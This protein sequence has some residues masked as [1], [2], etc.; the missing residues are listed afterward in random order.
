MNVMNVLVLGY[1]VTRMRAETET[2]TWLLMFNL[3][4]GK[5]TGHR[6]N[7]TLNTEES[8]LLPRHAN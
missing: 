7:P 6:L 4:E 5:Q 2:Y 8:L 3:H 1:H